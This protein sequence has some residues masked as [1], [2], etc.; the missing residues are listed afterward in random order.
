MMIVT[1]FVLTF[2]AFSQSISDIGDS[3]KS[4]MQF[5]MIGN[6]AL[7]IF[8]SASLNYLWGMI[9][10]LQIIVKIPLLQISFP[11]NAF[12]FYIFINNIAAFDIIPVNSIYSQMFSFTETL[13]F[14]TNLDNLDIF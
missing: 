10:T 6:F 12:M 3:M 13:P 11:S 5:I 4:G 14:S 7:N 8:L 9:N 1:F 2:L